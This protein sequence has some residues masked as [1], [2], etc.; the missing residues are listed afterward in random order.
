MPITSCPLRRLLSLVGLSI[1]AAS[2]R[3]CHWASLQVCGKKHHSSI[4]MPWKEVVFPVQYTCGRMALHLCYSVH[5]EPSSCRLEQSDHTSRMR[6]NP[7]SARSKP[8]LLILLAVSRVSGQTR[9]L[10]DCWSSP[11]LHPGFGNTL[12]PGTESWWSY[13]PSNSCR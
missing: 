4:Q 5:L 8:V 3:Q 1:R 11:S 12:E 10:Q 7:S 2:C 13:S 6:L 9:F